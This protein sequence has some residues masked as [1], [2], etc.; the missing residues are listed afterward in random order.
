M[1]GG[2]CVMAEGRCSLSSYATGK[3]PNMNG[4]CSPASH[5]E[6]REEGGRA[7]LAPRRIRHPQG[8]RGRARALSDA[9]QGLVPGRRVSGPC[10]RGPG[11]PRRG[12]ADPAARG[13]GRHGAEDRGPAAQPRLYDA[14]V[15][16]FR[17]ALDA[18]AAG[19]PIAAER[20]RELTEGQKT[21]AGAYRK[22][23]R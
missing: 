12:V 20:A 11:Q 23:W 4:A 3:S 8:R 2:L 5:V 17:A 14:V 18:Y 1:F 19:R 13:S 15:S 22:T 6:Y 7:G 10:V 21:T 9:L 16:G